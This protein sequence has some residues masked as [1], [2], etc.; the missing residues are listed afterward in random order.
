MASET[1]IDVSGISKIEGKSRKMQR[2]WT[3]IGIIGIIIALTGITLELTGFFR[4]EGI[5]ISLIG[6]LITLVASW[7]STISV[8]ERIDQ[9]T[10]ILC[11]ITREESEKTR[12]ELG[13]LLA[14]IRNILKG[15]R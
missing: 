13:K 3:I 9:K 11:T 2:F 8:F 14:E 12:K 7:Q 6:I 5:T 1:A 10:T 4:E 15:G